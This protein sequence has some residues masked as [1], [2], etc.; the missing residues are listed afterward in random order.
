MC[1][2]FHLVNNLSF[3]K[4]TYKNLTLLVVGGSGFLIASV[5]ASLAAAAG[6]G[7]LFRFL[8]VLINF[9]ILF[10]LFTFLINFSLPKRIGVADIR[11][12]AIFAAAGL[13]VLQLLGGYILAHELKIFDP[14]YSYFAISLG[15][16]FWIYL[17]SQ[18]LLYAIEVAIVSS[19]K[20]WPRSMD[21]NA[22][23]VVDKQMLSRNKSN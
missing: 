4:S 6:H 23:T 11:I 7:I 10:W 19:Q 13:V 14:L 8:S 2:I 20:L 3:P 16:L 15:L 12:G 9:V 18:M 1:G 5:S 22:P 21:S 17:Q